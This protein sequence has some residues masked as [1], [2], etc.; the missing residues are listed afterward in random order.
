MGPIYYKTESEIRKIRESSLIVS[1]TLAEVGK[2][3]KPGVTGLQL[4]KIAED[5]I[6]S[7]GAKPAFK[8]YKGFPG[9]L[10]ISVNAQVVHGIPGNYPL[11]EGDIISVDC[12]VVKDGFYGD[13][14]YTFAVGN[15]NAETAQLLK[16]TKESLYK[17]I[18]AA[19]CGNRIGDIGAAVQ[20]YVERYNYG[21]VRE[22]VGHG[23]GRNLHESPDV[24]NY[25][26]RGNGTAL[27]RGM[28]ICIEPMI[29]MGTRNVKQEADGWTMTTSDG[30][31]SA[32]FEHTIAITDGEAQILT[33]FGKIENI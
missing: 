33:T 6:K 1:D 19:R 30:K 13:S 22:L 25:G 32:H 3:I 23:I 17:G 15:I 11:K 27:K 26:K 14:A 9:T 28:V 8:G 2:A 31:P 18:E 16:I 7:V 10:C 21:V 5:Y 29:N 24:P 20:E 12:G 4:D